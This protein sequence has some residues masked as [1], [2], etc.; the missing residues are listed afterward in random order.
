[1]I[2]YSKLDPWSSLKSPVY[3]KRSTV[4]PDIITSQTS[5]DYVCP[6]V[7]LNQRQFTCGTF[8]KNGERC[9]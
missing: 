5:A 8:E 3:D 4:R 6:V 7:H 2:F 9:L 1:M